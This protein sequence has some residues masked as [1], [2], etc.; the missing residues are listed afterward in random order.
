MWRKW[1]LLFLGG[2]FSI[3]FS[4]TSGLKLQF[5]KPAHPYL[6]GMKRLVIAPCGE[7]DD[8]TMMCRFLTDL[9]EE[10]DYFSLFDRNQF[11]AALEQNQLTYQSI[12]QGDS[13]R[14]VAKLLD[15]D[16]VLFASLDAIKILPDEKGVEQVQKSV[17]TGEYERDENGRIIEEITATGE[18]QKKKKFKLQMV[19][20]HY[21]IR[22]AEC[23][24]NFQLIDLHNS[25]TILAQDLKERYASD[26][27]IQE[28]SQRAPGDDEIKTILLHR[29][30]R[31]FFDVIAPEIVTTRRTIE[32][33]TALLDSGAVYAR[34]GK[35]Q[36]AKKSW[37]QA[38]QERPADAR[39]YY[40]LGLACE[41]LADYESAEVY[42]KKASLLNP[43]KKK[44]QKA[45]ENIRK[46]WQEK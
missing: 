7:N 37:E 19:D 41:A 33:G 14:Q 8:A 10:S 2:V 32:T 22:K 42:Y 3:V 36:Q 28:E 4:C 13:T 35:W 15:V 39:A 11:A 30:A 46:M 21:R 26:K 9:I 1:S 31:R 5:Q 40:N 12:R 25:K 45:A 34:A 38:Q 20:Q 43:K 29:I 18:R 27:I 23:K 16:G 17:W 6:V 44:Y 24:A